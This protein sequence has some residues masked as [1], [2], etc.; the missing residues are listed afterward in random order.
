MSSDW[1]VLSVDEPTGE[2][3]IEALRHVVDAVDVRPP[4]TGTVWN[5]ST[6]GR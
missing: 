3:V 2:V 1:I 6:T 5:C 4:R